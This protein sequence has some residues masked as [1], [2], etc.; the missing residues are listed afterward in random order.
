MTVRL[1]KEEQFQLNLSERLILYY[2]KYPVRGA[3]DLLKIKLI[4]F[5]RIALRSMFKHKYIMLLFGRG[6]GKTWLGMV[7]CCLYAMLYPN[8]AIG[9]IA[10]SFKQTEFAFDKLEELYENSPYLRAAMTRRTMRATYKALAKFRNGSFI[11]GLPLGTGQK[12]RGRRYHIVWVDEYA[13]V[14]DIII[15]T[16]VRPFLKVKR[17][18]FDNKYIISSTA[19][20]VWNHLYTQ[21]LL[22]HYMSQQKP[23][24]YAVHEYIDEDVNMV[25]DPPFE[26][27]KEIDEMMRMDT[28]DELYKMEAK[29][30]FPVVNVGFFDARMLDRCTPRPTVDNNGVISSI[31]SPIEIEGEANGTYVLGIDTA[32]VAGGDNFSISVLKIDRGQKRFVNNYTYNGISYQ[33]MIIAIRKI[34]LKYNVI[35]LNIDAGGGGTTLK[36]LLTESYKTEDGKILP[37]ILDMDDKAVENIQGLHI[38]RMVNF[39][40]PSVTDL[41]TRLKA[42]FQHKNVLFPIDVRRSSDPEMER[43]GNDIIKTKREL[44]VLQA[45]NRGS[46]YTFDVPSQFKKDRATSLAL[47]NQAANEVAFGAMVKVEKTD[48]ADGFWIN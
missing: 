20:Y 14:D 43:A 6:I 25:P 44:L 45:E 28:T 16:V 23:D 27:D 34:M 38:L 47:A 2:R 11:E 36:D 37:P 41:Y 1:T 8:V 17:K 3:E 21:Y 7:F 12:V 29:C 19:Y 4:W 15:K 39:T 48:L 31:D 9:I 26:L 5:Q 10:P 42:D 18:G 22:Y 33:A 13:F 30:S 46:Y 40:L 24:M 35:Q 32:R